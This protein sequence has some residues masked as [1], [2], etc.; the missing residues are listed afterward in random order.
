MICFEIQINGQK[1]CQAGVG[2]SGVLTSVLSWV[3]NHQHGESDNRSVTLNV[4]GLAHTES[5]KDEFVDWVKKK[6]S[7]GDE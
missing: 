5:S 3:G 6:L 7:V 2:E 1:A 4:G